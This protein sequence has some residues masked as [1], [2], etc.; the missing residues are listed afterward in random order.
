M[1][2]VSPVQ[3]RPS[4]AGI[5]QRFDWRGAILLL[6]LCI[7][8]TAA[9]WLVTHLFLR[10]H[11]P[12]GNGMPPLP[13]FIL[14]GGGAFAPRFF[15]ALNLWEERFALAMTVA[16]IAS[17]LLAIKL[18]SFPQEAWLSESW[19]RQ[20]I[21]ALIFRSNH[22]ELSPWI[23]I[24]VAAYAWFRGRY[25]AEPSL[26]TAYTMLRY[27]TLVVL[28]T[29]LLH[30]ATGSQADERPVSAAVLIFFA[31]TL[32]GAALAHLWLETGR[33]RVPLGGRWVITLLSP[34]TIVIGLTLIAAAIFSPSVLDTI[35]WLAGPLLW[36]LSI[37]FRVLI[38]I[39]AVIAFVLVSP[40]LW[41][42]NGHQLHVNPISATP[43]PPQ[44]KENVRHS[45]EHFTTVP[46][47]IRYLIA[48]GVLLVILSFLTRFMLH[49]RRRVGPPPDEE[50]ESV[51]G[52]DDLLG[53][54]AALRW[55]R[56]P[57]AVDPLA[58]LRGDRMWAGT[59]T[60]RE[61]YRHFLVWSADHEVPRR[62]GTTPS[63]HARHVSRESPGSAGAHE[64]AA[65]TSGYN[66]ARY[67]ERPATPEEAEAVRSA[68]QRFKHIVRSR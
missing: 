3:T 20:T 11:G 26:D 65:I 10:G 50:R 5:Q 44:H 40:I 7:A 16:V 46:D 30:A 29:V 2:T 36:A 45:V 62:T 54:L 60:I 9:V 49:R 4:V 61:I 51:S 59:V 64:I 38:L 33:E 12:G 34:I 66:R 37:V 35:L 68:W 39:I 48:A 28:G 27:G 56:R 31:A 57:R 43:V 18:A 15:D 17:M 6:A 52:F 22:A 24:I 23:V 58:A 41:L 25:R 63:E 21:R 55:R 67:G 8:E 32:A 1:N 14:V 42:L 53:A 47:P 13:L 19:L